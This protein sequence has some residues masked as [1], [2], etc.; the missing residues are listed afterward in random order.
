MET[1]RSDEKNK[2]RFGSLIF[3]AVVIAILHPLSVGPVHY[4]HARGWLSDDVSKLIWAFYYPEMKILELTTP[5]TPVP[6]EWL[7]AYCIAWRRAAGESL[8]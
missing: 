2:S 5:H 3:W 4:A 7:S 1:A 6:Q 8:R